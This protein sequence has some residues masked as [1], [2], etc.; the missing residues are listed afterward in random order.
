MI[1]KETSDCHPGRLI[2]S[3]A[4]GGSIA[5]HA[6]KNDNTTD[7]AMIIANAKITMAQ[8]ITPAEQQVGGKAV[9]SGIGDQDGT[10]YF[11]V[12]VVKDGS[13]QKLLIDPQSG[14]IIKTA[15]A[16]NERNERGPESDDD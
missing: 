9:G 1:R 13:R 2:A 14:K 8:A 12:Q 16:D 4:V 11:E 7:E 5:A 6:R 15:A 3:S 10:F